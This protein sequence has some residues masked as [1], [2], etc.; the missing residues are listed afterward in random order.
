MWLT[1]KDVLLAI[2][3]VDVAAEGQFSL[4]LDASDQLLRE[5]DA[6]VRFL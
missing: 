5:V 1:Y 6:R 4:L 3:A 2:V